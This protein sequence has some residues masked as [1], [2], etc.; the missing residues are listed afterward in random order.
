MRGGTLTNMTVIGEIIK[1]YKVTIVNRI[2]SPPKD[3]HVP[4]SK[5]R[6][7]FRYVAKRN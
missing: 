4:S 3:V 1:R 2:I 5:T 7:M 6:N